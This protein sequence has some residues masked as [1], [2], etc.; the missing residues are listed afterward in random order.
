[1]TKHLYF[2][3][4]Q[5]LNDL[6]NSEG[7]PLRRSEFRDQYGQPLREP[8]EL[9][10]FLLK[11]DLIETENDPDAFFL[12]PEAYD[13]FEE[14][15][16]N[17]FL[18]DALNLDFDELGNDN[19]RDLRYHVVEPESREKQKP[20]YLSNSPRWVIVGFFC[21]ILYVLYLI[22]P[23]DLPVQ[24]NQGPPPDILEPLK[25]STFVT[26]D[27]DTIRVFEEKPK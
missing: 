4:L 1:M 2:I 23:V 8:N 21:G 12:T 26:E 22:L 24:R 5:N 11:E 25:N 6:Y 10:S 3:S 16:L 27:G 15:R 7:E 13:L 9:I 18:M 20:S 19:P 17:G 14:G